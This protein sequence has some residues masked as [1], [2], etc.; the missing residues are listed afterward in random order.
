MSYF[1]DQPYKRFY[2]LCR[3]NFIVFAEL[4]S[5]CSSNSFPQGCSE[6]VCYN[7][8]VITNAGGFDD[9]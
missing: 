8:Y 2:E 7:L 6:F 9:G 4:F 1:L 3:L 5:V